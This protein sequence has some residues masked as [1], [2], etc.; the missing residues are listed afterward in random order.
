MTGGAG[1]KLSETINMNFPEHEIIPISKLSPFENNSRTHSDDQIKQ[2]ANSIKEFG[3]TN[4][5]LID[6]KNTIIAGH[7]RV[8]A[9]KSLDMAGLPA[10]RLTGLSDTQRRALVIADNQLALN[11][12]WDLD[13][14]KLE[15]ETL[16]EL[17]FDID[18]LGF[19]D[20]FL[21]GLLDEEPVD[22]LTDEDAVP[23]PPE[24]PVSVLGDIWQLGNH[25][26]MCGDSTSIDAVEKLM[27]GHKADMVFTD[28]PY[29]ISIVQNN[30]IGGGGAFGKGKQA[31]S[32]G[33]HIAANKYAPVAGDESIDV[34]VDAIQVIKTLGAK[35]E[36]IWGGNYYAQHL[37]NSK[38]W[39]VWDKQTG[40]STFADAELAWTNQD[41]KVRTFQHRWSGICK[42]SE[43][44]EKRVH[45]T[46]KPIALAEWC[47]NIYGQKCDTILDLF[48]GSGFTLMAC[49]TKD[50]KA[51]VMEMAEP[52]ID[53]IINRWQKFTGKEAIHIESGKTYNEL[54]ISKNV[55]TGG[56]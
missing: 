53:V 44:G 38:C 55:D 32:G 37:G 47:F 40:D 25:R 24:T 52:Y 56:E 1:L 50:K 23:E 6:E 26:L 34:A 31:K 17:D 5:I 45:P 18:L 22:G 21:S 48:G 54:S 16:G 41:T 7:G 36:I 42:A 39:V 3:F 15:I 30:Q 20:D 13:K 19:D 35:V 12:D 11:A 2:V 43:H 28:P 4:P 33:K 14:L 51:F 49:E 27:D 46:Q 29:G 10:I 8:L 9:A